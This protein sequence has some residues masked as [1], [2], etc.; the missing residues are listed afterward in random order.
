MQTSA[1]ITYLDSSALVKL[2][3]PEPE[4]P[5]LRRFLGER[6]ER[7]SA[8]LCRVEVMRAAR[9]RGPDVVAAAQSVLDGLELLTL[10]DELLD[11]A[12]RLDPP[13]LRSLD[14]IHIAA[15]LALEQP[16]ILFVT[17]D[18]RQTAAARA[19]GLRVTAPGDP[20]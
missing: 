3:E 20:D 18:E 7:V 4:T 16:G 10:T 15:A 11:A 14:A 6:S 13:A 17:Y 12:G 5:A 1:E 2:I 8:A 9:R 19:A